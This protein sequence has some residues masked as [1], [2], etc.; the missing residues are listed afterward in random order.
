M[1]DV[2]PTLVDDTRRRSWWL[3]LHVDMVERALSLWRLDDAQRGMQ[4][5]EDAIAQRRDDVDAASLDRA[6]DVAIRVSAAR[7]DAAWIRWVLDM[8]VSARRVPSHA[9]VD[10]L[11][12]LP[13]ILMED[14]QPALQRMTKL[15]A[16]GANDETID[17]LDALRV[18]CFEVEQLRVNSA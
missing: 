18:L 2:I 13:P 12:A 6:F 14:A 17:R 3:E 10:R 11:R 1:H 4:R 9:L 7:G 8:Q 15:F 16:H 5:I